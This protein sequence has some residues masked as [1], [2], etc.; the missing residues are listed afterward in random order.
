M[1]EN[2]LKKLIQ[3][4]TVCTTLANLFE[5]ED[6]LPG[7][8]DAQFYFERYEIIGSEFGKLVRYFTDFDA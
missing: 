3:I 8:D 4:T 1:M 2:I 7:Y 6:E 5:S